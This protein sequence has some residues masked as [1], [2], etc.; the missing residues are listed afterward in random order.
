MNRHFPRYC[1]VSAPERVLKDPSVQ[2]ILLSPNATWKDQT[3]RATFQR[4]LPKSYKFLQDELQAFIFKG[5]S[6]VGEA[7]TP[8]L[9]ALL[10]GRTVEENC[11]IHEARTGFAGAR[12]V[13]EW[14]FIFK[15]LKKHGYVTLFSEDAPPMGK[16]MISFLV[17]PKHQIS[18]GKTEWDLGSR[19]SSAII[20]YM[21]RRT[22]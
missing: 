17:S 18:H 15:T 21:H 6:L 7:T 1:V 20:M 9:T 3:S 22:E 8:Q 5:F 16:K 4:L 12:T 11:E 10:T 2:Q 13:D 14:P 19:L